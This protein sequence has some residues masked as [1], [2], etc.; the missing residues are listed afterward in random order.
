MAKEVNKMFP[1][2]IKLIEVF[3]NYEFGTWCSSSKSVTINY[4]FSSIIK[5][6]I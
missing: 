6:E 2:N 3:L 1:L 5:R 4:K